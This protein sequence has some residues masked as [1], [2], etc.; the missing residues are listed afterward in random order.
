MRLF[1]LLQLESFAQFRSVCRH[2]SN[3]ETELG[4]ILTTF[5]G[6]SRQTKIENV[7]ERQHAVNSPCSVIICDLNLV[8]FREPSGLPISD[9]VTRITPCT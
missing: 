5:T 2:L 6:V 8:F 1:Q 4:A 7:S 3:L 9:T